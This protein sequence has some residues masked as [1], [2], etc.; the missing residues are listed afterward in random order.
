MDS[1]VDDGAVRQRWGR[2]VSQTRRPWSEVL[3]QAMN[4]PPEI[5]GCPCCCESLR[6]MRVL[7]DERMLLCKQY[8]GR[9]LRTTDRDDSWIQEVDEIT[10]EE[11]VEWKERRAEAW[12]WQNHGETRSLMKKP[13]VCKECK[14]C[15][16]MEPVGQMG[17]L[18]LW[19]Q[20]SASGCAG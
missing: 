4:T 7:T 10:Q 8:S 16:K 19:Q 20:R 5:S 13:G 18:A 9:G 15:S 1:S 11:F 14:T 2:S 6:W 12:T 17:G 3:F